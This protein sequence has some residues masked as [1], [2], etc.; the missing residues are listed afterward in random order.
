MLLEQDAFPGKQGLLAFV[1][2]LLSRESAVSREELAS[3]LWPEGQPRA[4]DAALNSIASKLR[5]LLAQAGLDKSTVLP[6]TL[7][8]YQVNLPADAW[9]DVE[10]AAEALHEAEDLLKAGRHR[11]CWAMAQVAFHICKRPF[12]PGETSAWAVQQRERFMV[13]FARAGECLVESYIW[14]GEPSVAVDVAEQVVAAQPYRETAYQF[15]MRAHAAAGNR[16]EAL[17]TFERCRKLISEELGVDPSSETSAV[18]HQIL[19][20]R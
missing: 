14:N 7:G 18:H 15:L 6:A 8:C 12:L 1:R 19:H 5:V 11:E 4:W 17:W 13:W 3:L 10:A 20:T 9:V 2:L 16:A